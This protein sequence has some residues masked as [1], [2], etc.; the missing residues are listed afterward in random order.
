MPGLEKSAIVEDPVVPLQWQEVVIRLTMMLIMMMIFD[1][2]MMLKMMT[3]FN[4]IMILVMMIILVLCDHL[5]I[6]HDENH[7][8]TGRQS[9]GRQYRVVP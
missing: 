2:T 4:S 3:I 7:L 6:C 8:M 5:M 9:R 1:L